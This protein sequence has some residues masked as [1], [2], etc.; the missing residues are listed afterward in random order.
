MASHQHNRKHIGRVANIVCGFPTDQPS[1]RRTV[2]KCKDIEVNA[3]NERAEVW[4]QITRNKKKQ[5]N[6]KEVYISFTLNFKI[7]KTKK[8]VT[9]YP[10]KM[11][12]TFYI[13]RLRF[14]R[15]LKITDNKKNNKP[16]FKKKIK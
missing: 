6:V 7:P 11:C 10:T 5:Q 8:N 14:I 4:L 2:K 9:L 1:N 12:F 16:L 15:G 13:K 3:G